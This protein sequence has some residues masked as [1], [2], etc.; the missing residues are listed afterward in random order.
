MSSSVERPSSG[1]ARKRV[2][3]VTGG[4]AGIGQAYAVRLAQDGHEV[5]I[6]DLEPAT[7][8]LDLISSLGHAGWA[9]YCD[10]SD[11]DSV[12]AFSG[13]ALERFGSADIL[14]A[15][16]GIYATTPFEQLSWQEWR[17]VM[18]VNLDSLFR[19]TKAFLPGM[20]ERKWGRIIAQSSVVVRTGPENF[21]HY[22]AS[23]AGVTGFV[24][25]L[26]AEV[27]R[28][29][30]TANCIAP[31][32]VRSKGTI[33]GP[34]ESL[35]WFE[36]LV[37]AQAIKRTQLPIDLVGALSFLASD[38][39]AFMTGQTLFVDGGLVRS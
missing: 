18:S 34:H 1:Q 28:H 25:S 12:S 15:N 6:A 3:V 26:A 39:S 23:K 38:D 16:A 7:E 36:E 10:V 20:V 22:T 37:E 29:G 27:A 17:R 11:P 13:L 32:L 14:G 2:A 33:E 35:G 19:L 4:A 24:H 5:A 8:T 21:V 30:V 9:R 31:S